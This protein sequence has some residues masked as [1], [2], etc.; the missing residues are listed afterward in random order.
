MCYCDLDVHRRRF[1]DDLL[2]LL[3]HLL[4]WV[5][6]V[7][8]QRKVIRDFYSS[9]VFFLFTFRA[10]GFVSLDE[11]EVVLGTHIIQSQTRALLHLLRSCHLYELSVRSLLKTRSEIL[12]TFRLT[13]SP[14][15]QQRTRN[16]AVVLSS[17]EA[18]AARRDVCEGKRVSS[19]NETR[20]AITN[21]RPRRSIVLFDSAATSAFGA[22]LAVATCD[23]KIHLV[24]HTTNASA[25]RTRTFVAHHID[26]MGDADS[27]EQCVCGQSDNNA[28]FVRVCISDDKYVSFDSACNVGIVD[29]S[30]QLLP[31]SAGY[32]A[33]AETSKTD[34]VDSILKIKKRPLTFSASRL[35]HRDVVAVF[36]WTDALSVQKKRKKN[37]QHVS[38]V[39]SRRGLFKTWKRFGR[40]RVLN[41]AKQNLELR[42]CTNIDAVVVALV[43]DTRR[44]DCN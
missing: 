28:N 27:F 43:L 14:F 8:D 23:T 30:M 41:F 26:Y 24:G 3:R 7:P 37:T 38:V 29:S 34:M 22:V 1:L 13:M 42:K 11:D 44:F 35:R 4:T 19:P 36:A 39:N 25:R 9:L 10:S 2:R 33:L 20:S 15:Q 31:A 40:T 6:D 5:G 18:S 32:F 12:N 17:D 21:S 16:D